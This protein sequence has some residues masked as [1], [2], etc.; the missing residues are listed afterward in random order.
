MTIVEFSVGFSD[1]FEFIT[2]TLIYTIMD[3]YFCWVLISFAKSK[4][5]T[6]V[7]HKQLS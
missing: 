7:P 5:S 4:K 2:L 1:K 6:E 3:L